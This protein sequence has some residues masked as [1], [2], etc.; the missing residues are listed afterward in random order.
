RTSFTETTTGN[1]PVLDFLS[2]EFGY[3]NKNGNPYFEVRDNNTDAFGSFPA[4]IDEFKY[5]I[6]PENS[7]MFGDD[8]VMVKD[9]KQ[10]V[11]V[12]SV[13][14]AAYKKWAKD[15]QLKAGESYTIGK[16]DFGI[17]GAGR[18]WLDSENTGKSFGD[19]VFST[20]HFLGSYAV[21]I[22]VMGDGKTL[23][24]TV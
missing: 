1:L 16:G 15:G 5:E 13:V 21:N 9:I 3:P 12:Q 2:S 22:F 19:R 10:L 14:E 18:V 8:Q 11:G 4:L 17:G 7:V 23:L 6:G 20:E 24:F